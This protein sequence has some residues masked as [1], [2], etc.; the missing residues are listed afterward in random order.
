MATFPVIADRRG[1]SGPTDGLFGAFPRVAVGGPQ[2]A[3]PTAWRREPP[4]AAANCQRAA[5]PQARQGDALRLGAC[6][7]GQVFR[8]RTGRPDGL[9][10]EH[11][12]LRVLVWQA[13]RRAGL[14]KEAARLLRTSFF[15]CAAAQCCCVAATQLGEVLGYARLC[16]A[17]ARRDRRH[18][19]SG[20]ECS[21]R[22]LA[23]QKVLK[24][25]SQVDVLYG[26]DY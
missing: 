4:C 8:D 12:P 19:R 9:A 11:V 14:C 22:G 3:A 5:T 2:R 13:R 10:V 23:C 26:D 7:S 16:A 15:G 21:R 1:R 17:S 6:P 20:G 18:R 25:L 24:S